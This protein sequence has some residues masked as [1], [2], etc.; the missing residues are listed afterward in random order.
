MMKGTPEYEAAD[1][2]LKA[3]KVY[4]DW[5]RAPAARVVL[6][7][8]CQ[9]GVAKAEQREACVETTATGVRWTI[10]GKLAQAIQQLSPTNQEHGE[11]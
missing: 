10:T 2:E 8:P 1:A 5:V 4:Q 3:S 7:I 9:S 11:G 6:D